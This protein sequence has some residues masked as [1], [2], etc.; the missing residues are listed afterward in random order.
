MTTLAE[1]DKAAETLKEAEVTFRYRGGEV[2]SDTRK[3]IFIAV[4]MLRGKD[5]Q[6]VFAELRLAV[7]ALP[8]LLKVARA[9]QQRVEDEGPCERCAADNSMCRADPIN[10]NCDCHGGGSEAAVAERHALRELE[11]GRP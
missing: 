10:C 8:A 7:H 3:A 4:D 11:G 2:L 5:A 6:M 1:L 9:A